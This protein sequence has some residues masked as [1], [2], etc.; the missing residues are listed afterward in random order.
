MSETPAPLPIDE[1]FDLTG[2]VALVTGASRG[3][4]EAIARCYAAAGA[5][6]VLAS[7]TQEALDAVAA[8]IRED[9]GTALPVACHTGD[10]DQVAALVHRV[11][12]ELGGVDVLV[13]NAGTNPHFGPLLSADESHW[14]KTLDV[15]LFGYV[16]LAKACVPWMRE[17]RDGRRGGKIINVA[18][19]V[20]HTPHPGLGVYAVSKA[21]VLM[22][23]RVLALELA[24]D[25]IQ[26]NALAPG[27]IETRFS[28]ALWKD[29]ARSAGFLKDIPAGRFGHTDDL[30]GL[31][32][33][34]ASR[35][36]DFTTGAVFTVDGGQTVG[37]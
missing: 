10:A 18:S 36:S 5:S 2:K 31:A 32:L 21:A 33:Y 37:G 13:N 25:G 20:G 26:V 9:G 34:L 1:L 27:I 14:H 23:T 6:V 4:G 16:R 19:I 3:I 17:P 35:A 30:L 24:A 12:D 15:N 28:E 29:P 8:S 7:R 22:L 11:R